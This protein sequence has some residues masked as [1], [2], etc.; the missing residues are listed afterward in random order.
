MFRPS[1]MSEISASMAES[2]LWRRNNITPVAITKNTPTSAMTS[3]RSRGCRRSQKLGPLCL[4]STIAIFLAR[5]GARTGGRLCARFLGDAEAAD[6][7]VVVDR[8]LERLAIVAIP[9]HALGDLA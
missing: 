3:T 4:A 2:L 5:F 1:R 7:A 8:H 9:D 6:V